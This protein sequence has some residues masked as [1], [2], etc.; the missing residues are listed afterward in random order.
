MNL[1]KQYGVDP[2]IITAI[3]GYGKPVRALSWQLS[4]DKILGF[5]S[6]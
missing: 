1:N 3:L 2:C 4:G 5:F 6:L